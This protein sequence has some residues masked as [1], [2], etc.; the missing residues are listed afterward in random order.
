M[1]RIPDVEIERAIKDYLRT[2]NE[3]PRRFTW[4]KTADQIL[5]SIRRFCMRTSDS[6]H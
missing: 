4:T 5:D 3:D 6:R 1:A 2:H